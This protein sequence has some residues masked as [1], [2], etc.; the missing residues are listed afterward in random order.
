MH[1]RIYSTSLEYDFNI[2]FFL[3]KEEHW[4]SMLAETGVTVTEFLL[5]LVN[6]SIMSQRKKLVFLHTFTTH[7]PF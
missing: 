1:I 6:V 2:L 3:K 4:E 5:V 7:Y